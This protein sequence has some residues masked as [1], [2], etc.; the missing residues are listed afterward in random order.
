LVLRKNT[1]R[2]VVIDHRN[3]RQEV[4]STTDLIALPVQD[5]S[6]AAQ[7]PRTFMRQC[8]K[9]LLDA[10]FNFYQL[11]RP[12]EIAIF[13]H[14]QLKIRSRPPL[15][16]RPALQQFPP[17]RGPRKSLHGIVKGNRKQDAPNDAEE[18]FKKPIRKVHRG[19]S[20]QV[21]S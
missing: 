14:E 11:V 19:Y 6:H 13:R 10:R 9:S 3:H 2:V 15:A 8:E 18:T 12:L 16:F 17:A 5:T 20:I 7:L 21:K 1:E 4:A